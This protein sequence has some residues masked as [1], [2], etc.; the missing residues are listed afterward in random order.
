MKGWNSFIAAWRS[1]GE[2]DNREM[3]TDSGF[4]LYRPVIWGMGQVITSYAS[5][6]VQRSAP[7]RLAAAPSL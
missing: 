7:S 6:H 4:S 3:A 5:A 2:I 1:S